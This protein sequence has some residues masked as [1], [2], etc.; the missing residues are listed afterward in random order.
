MLFMCLQA[1]PGETLV[2]YLPL[3]HIAAAEC[4]Q[5]GAVIVGAAV[6]FA[7]PD[8]L[9]GTLVQASFWVRFA[10][11]LSLNAMEIIAAHRARCNAIKNYEFA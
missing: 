3:S 8:A 7:M 11:I 6:S 5:F 4:D 2:S 1:Q 10:R 9:K